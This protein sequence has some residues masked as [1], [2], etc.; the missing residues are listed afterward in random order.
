MCTKFK[1]PV[2]DDGKKKRS[3]PTFVEWQTMM[4]SGCAERHEKNRTVLSMNDFPYYFDEGIEHWIVWKLGGDNISLDE[5]KNGKMDI[6]KDAGFSNMDL[7]NDRS[8][9][10]HFLNPTGLKSLPE[11]DH[12]HILFRRAEIS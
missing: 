10:L 3:K 6:L 7:I 8:V 1:F 4:K 2:E 5:I 11:I 9:F 12:I